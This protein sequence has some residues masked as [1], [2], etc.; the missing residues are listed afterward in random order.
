MRIV[1]HLGALSSRRRQVHVGLQWKA[2]IAFQ[3][4]AKQREFR[5]DIIQKRQCNGRAFVEKLIHLDEVETIIVGYVVVR[6]EVAARVLQKDGRISP[7]E[8]RED[9]V[10]LVE[11]QQRAE[12]VPLI[13]LDDKRLLFPIILKKRAAVDRA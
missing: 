11:R 6:S 8:R 2:E 3:A 5:D 7:I 1:V 13:A 9:S 12:I 4:P 10:H